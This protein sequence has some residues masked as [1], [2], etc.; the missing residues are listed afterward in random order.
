[1]PADA[2]AW[3]FETR[4]IHSGATPDPATGAR[5]TPIYQTTSFVFRDTAHAAALFSLA[6]AGHIYTRINNPTQ[7]VLEQ[8]IAALEGGVAAVAFASGQAAET[9]AILNLAGAGDHF[10]SSA[11]LY[12]GTY[13]LFHYT[14]P[15]L[16]IEVSF[17]DDP[18]NLDEWRAAVRPDTK[19]FFAETLGNPRSN[20]LD[21]AAVAGVAHEVG[22]PL[23]VDN[24]V[25]TPY[26][27]RPIE[28]GADIVVHSATKFLGGHGT[29][30]AGVVV[31]GGTFDF[32]THADRF[33]DYNEPDPSYHGLQYWPALGH[34]AYA[35]KL[36]VQLLRDT[37]AAIAPQNSFLI[38]QGIETLSL[39][40][41]RHVANAQAIAEWLEQRDE[42]ETVHYA[43]LP[44]SPWYQAGQKYL[45]G[46]AG[47][48]VSLELRGGA[49]AGR[50]FVDGTELF[51]NLANIG[52]V[53]SLIVHPASTTHSQLTP[54]EQAV[55]GV[56]P[57]LVR[58]SVGLEGVEDLKADLDAGFRAAKAAL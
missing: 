20:V 16:G 31:D 26:L 24:T 38:L 10:V 46:G 33:P 41:E 28:H 48:I 37:G 44:S 14:L 13:N 43:G 54:E 39:R 11:S 55:T 56:T 34:G 22:V 5:A 18:D 51:S 40:I 17:V 57:G 25:P 42:V 35:A 45:P 29:A 9:A 52:D 2:S 27:V 36:R 4:Q 32:G 3:S 7:D 19:L 47:A 21:I 6:E 12:G 15:K 49:E 58:L 50:A 1:M 23:V 53:R 8:R 30:I